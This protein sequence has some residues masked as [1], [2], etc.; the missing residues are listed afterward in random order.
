MGV[1]KFLFGQDTTSR[2]QRDQ[3][4]PSTISKNLI[5]PINDYGTCFACDGTGERTLQCHACDGSGEHVGQCHNCGGIGQIRRAAKPCFRCQGTGK[6][7]GK[8]CER[9]QGTGNFKPAITE[10]CRGCKGT[11]QFKATCRKC[12]G[13]GQFTGCAMGTGSLLVSIVLMW[14]R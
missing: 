14:G 2:A 13:D 3:Y 9:C 12:D 4:R 8:A 6:I 7:R 11:G 5:S 10:A 1:F